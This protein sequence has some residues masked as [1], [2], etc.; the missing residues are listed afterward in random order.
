MVT[1]VLLVAPPSPIRTQGPP[2]MMMYLGAALRRAGKEVAVLDMA[3]PYG[4]RRAGDLQ[5]SIER[6]DPTVL[7]MTLF[8]ETTLAGYR[9]LE[10]LGPAPL[11]QV[12]VAG[13]PHA[14]AVPEEPLDR[15]FDVVVRGEGEQTL[16]E[17][18]EAMERG[19]SLESVQGLCWRDSGGVLHRTPDR[20]RLRDLDEL[21]RPLE[22]HDLFPREWYIPPY[23]SGSMH[24]AIITSRGCP[25]ACTFCSNQVTGRSYRYHSPDRVLQEMQDWHR[26]EGACS[27][28]FHDDAFTVQRER[29]RKLCRGMR[30]LEFSPLWWC[31]AR[32]DQVDAERAEAM[33]RSGCSTVVLGAESGDP[34]V[35][36]RIGKGITPQAVWDAL[37]AARQAGLRTQLNFMFGFPDETEAELDRTLAFMQRVAALVDGFTPMG[38]VVPYPGT[39]LYRG[40]HRQKG[41]SG[42][43]LQEK[44]VRH[45]QVEVPVERMLGATVD[46][47]IELHRSLEQGV[48]DAGLIPYKP[49]V[50]AAIQRCL[51]FRREH[52]RGKMSEWTRGTQQESEQDG[53]HLLA[54]EADPS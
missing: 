2:L 31:E 44:R 30:D 19:G 8:T 50:R 23:R 43:W 14:T 33:A 51:E 27:F 42:W 21:P 11:G 5:A 9:L 36:D 24:A 15:G 53:L 13:G 32:A 37:L 38:V 1:R 3:S 18:V 34:G 49:E 10:E 45:L 39:A 41:F 25:G 48:L 35:L 46:D 26:L 20:A 6:L 47:I 4:P 16:V 52:N 54:G 12:R 17:L 28:S 22:A 40:F 29:L 7:G